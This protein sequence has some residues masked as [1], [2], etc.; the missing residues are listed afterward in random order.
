M[1]EYTTSRFK[2]TFSD[3]SEKRGG[4]AGG[5]GGGGGVFFFFFSFSSNEIMSNG[6]VSGAELIC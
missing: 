6:G 4:L 3:Q 1:F 2:N 5:G